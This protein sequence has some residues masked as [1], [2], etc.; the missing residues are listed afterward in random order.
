MKYVQKGLIYLDLFMQFVLD[1]PLLGIFL[2]VPATNWILSCSAFNQFQFKFF[3]N[4]AKSGIVTVRKVAAERSCF[5]RCLSVYRAVGIHPP[6]ADTPLGRYPSKADILRVD[7]PVGRPPPHQTATAADGTYPTGTHTC[8][9]SVQFYFHVLTSLVIS[10]NIQKL[11]R[12]LNII[13]YQ[14]YDWL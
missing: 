13:F 10:I 3:R 4:Y 5:P 9:V 2:G 12:R 14:T 8:C 11:N 7:T 6:W 1:L